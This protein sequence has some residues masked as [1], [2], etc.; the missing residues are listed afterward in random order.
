MPTLALKLVLTPL[1][2]AAASLAGR[3]WGP[4]ISGWLVGLPFTSG[5]IAFFLA[6]AHGTTFASADAVGT[7]AGTLSQTAF[8]LAYA[9]VA[10]CVGRHRSAW[11]VAFAFAAG[12]LAF[13]AA[14]VLLAHFSLSL[15]P[16]IPLVV[17]ALLLALWLMPGERLA[18]EPASLR[19][20]GPRPPSP[21]AR[22]EN[23]PVLTRLLGEGHEQARL[24]DARPAAPPRWDLPLRMAVAT[25]FVVLLTAAAPLL[26]AR[27]T[28]LLAP[29]PLFASVLAVFSHMQRGP[30]VAAG[31]LRGLLLGLFAFAGFFV[32]LAQLLAPA[33]IA[34]AFAAAIAAALG[35]QGCSLWLLRS[36][37]A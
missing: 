22:A 4:A 31:V 27:L 30:T 2:I 8:C 6:L 29:F 36:R 28:G 19:S 26:G 7:L 33:G 21:P 1:L 35:I 14:T 9:W 12:T 3:R 37:S 18:G 25:A 32:A 16:L 10:I 24:E 17:V 13:V 20:R 34:L 15:A 5:P 11:P 23:G